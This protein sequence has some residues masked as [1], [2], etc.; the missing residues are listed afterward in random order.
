MVVSDVEIEL[1]L[2]RANKSRLDTMRVELNWAEVGAES[3]SL[4]RNGELVDTVSD[5]GR[6][7]D[8]VRNA[9]LPAYD[10]QLCVSE[11]VC[12]NIITVS[13]SE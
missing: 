1:S 3:L 8:Y 9:T 12:S 4:Y 2:K 10:Y 7:R 11:N 13:F 6:Y 5:N